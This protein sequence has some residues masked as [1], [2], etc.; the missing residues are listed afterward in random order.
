MKL[1]YKVSDPCDSR[2]NRI[3]PFQFSNLLGTVYHKGNLL[4]TPD[5]NALI[6]PVGNRA[7]VIDLKK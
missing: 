6:T 5:S 2:S 1:H 3:D 7:T 4:F